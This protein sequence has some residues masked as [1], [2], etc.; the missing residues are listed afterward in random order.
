MSLR[1]FKC[2]GELREVKLEAFCPICNSLIYYEKTEYVEKRL[3]MACERLKRSN[4]VNHPQPMQ[5]TS[6]ESK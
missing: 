2:K 3:K 6:L 5:K 1:C 4:I